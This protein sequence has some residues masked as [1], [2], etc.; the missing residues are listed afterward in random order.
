M[1]RP[2]S[3]TD[4]RQEIFL[5]VQRLTENLVAAGHS[6]RDVAAVLFLAGSGGIVFDPKIAEDLIGLRRLV[7]ELTAVVAMAEQAAVPPTLTAVN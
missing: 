6:P 3:T 2:M 7:G 4:T 5:A 1:A